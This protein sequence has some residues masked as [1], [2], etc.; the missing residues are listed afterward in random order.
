MPDEAT[1]LS[2]AHIHTT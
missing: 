1:E 2:S